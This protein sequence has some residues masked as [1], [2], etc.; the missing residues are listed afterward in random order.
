MHAAYM[1][2]PALG[3]DGV[4]SGREV[5]RRDHVGDAFLFGVLMR[6]SDI[7]SILLVVLRLMDTGVKDQMWEEIW[8]SI[9]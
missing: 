9:S 5:S 7:I 4:R 3:H 8:V 1:E 2:P 6:R